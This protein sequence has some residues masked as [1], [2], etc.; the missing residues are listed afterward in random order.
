MLL[1]GMLGPVIVRSIRL[2]VTVSAR[3]ER[4]TVRLSSEM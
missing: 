4:L 1:A 2:F 3:Q